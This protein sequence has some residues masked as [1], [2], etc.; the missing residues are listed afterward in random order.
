[1]PPSTEADDDSDMSDGEKEVV[2]ASVEKLMSKKKQVSL[3][4]A[5]QRV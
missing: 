3:L 2:D 4:P 5:L 1:M